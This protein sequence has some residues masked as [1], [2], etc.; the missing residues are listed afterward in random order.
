[1]SQPPQP[2]LGQ[3]QPPQWGQYSA[4][5]QPAPKKRKKWPWILAAIVAFFVVVGIV[6]GGDDKATTTANN[7]SSADNATSLDS[8]VADNAGAADSSKSVAGIGSEVRD[9][10]FA[11][12]VTDIETGVT[13]AGD[14]PYVNKVPQGQFVFVHVDVT[15]IGD[16]AQSYFGSNQKL[17]DAQ[18]REFSNDTAAEIYANENFTVGDINP[19]NTASVI[20]VFDVPVDAQPKT[21]E[22][23]DS[24]FSGGATVSVG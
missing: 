21:V 11:F 2:P 6:G 17:Y 12:V 8:G 19:G 9:G 14:N 5:Q 10:K 1:M 24:M 23:H 7:D 18:G 3:Q 13:Q 4:P 22:L 20:V 16:K 15:N